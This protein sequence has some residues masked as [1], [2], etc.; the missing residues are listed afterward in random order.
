MAT[1]KKKT[2]SQ[3][4]GKT[5]LETLLVEA[6]KG[7][8]TTIRGLVKFCTAYKAAVEL[9]GQEGKREFAKKFSLYSD[10]DW[11]T[12][13]DIATG[14]LLPQFAFCSN[15]MKR[16]LLRLTNSIEKQ[17][18]LVGAV[19]DG[20]KIETV[21]SS[22][23]IVLKSLEELSKLEEDSWLFALSEGGDPNE[24]R[25]LLYTYRK[26]FALRMSGKPNVEIVGD[27]LVVNR[28]TTLSREEVQQW[29]ARMP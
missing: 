9:Y 25:K 18:K 1:K 11:A 12:F 28:K 17:M 26:E 13:E 5:S 14:K 22:G 19:K 21:N 8:A 3:D 16:G 7:Y 15:N 29:L 4:A 27:L 23:K 10:S 2:A 20:S 6:G 24:I